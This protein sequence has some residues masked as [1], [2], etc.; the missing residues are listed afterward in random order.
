M[1]GEKAALALA[2][3]FKACIMKKNYAINI[4]Y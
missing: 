1:E 3:F 2:Y 4:L